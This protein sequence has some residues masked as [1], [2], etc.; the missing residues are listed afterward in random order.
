M[1]SCE[2]KIWIDTSVMSLSSFEIF[3]Q[4]LLLIDDRLVQIA[5]VHARLSSL[6]QVPI[7]RLR[8]LQSLVV[9]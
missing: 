2:H 6:Y 8:A 7:H 9:F 5:F 4:Y 1:N 3:W